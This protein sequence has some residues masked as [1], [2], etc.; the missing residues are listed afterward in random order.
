MSLWPF[1]QQATSPASD[2]GPYLAQHRGTRYQTMSEPWEAIEL[3]Q[4]K[5]KLGEVDTAGA[6]PAEPEQAPAVGGGE[7]NTAFDGETEEKTQL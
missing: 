2:W 4:A 7:E 5:E 3:Q 1:P 6:A